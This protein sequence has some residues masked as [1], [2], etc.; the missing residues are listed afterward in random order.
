MREIT[1]LEIQLIRHLLEKAGKQVRI[2]KMVRPLKDGKM[3]SIS[4]DLKGLQESNS[5][6]IGGSFFDSDGVLVD[7]ELTADKNNELYELDMWK[8]DFSRLLRYPDLNEL[9]VT[10]LKND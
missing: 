6:I 7:F 8:V 2:P 1:E 3:G 10:P 5:P 4:F 9:K